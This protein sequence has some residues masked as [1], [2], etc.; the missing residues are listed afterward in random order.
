MFGFTNHSTPGQSVNDNLVCP[1][2]DDGDF[3][4]VGLKYHL[5][6]GHCD[7]FNA[8]QTETP[9]AG[10]IDACAKNV[11]DTIAVQFVDEMSF[12]KPMKSSDGK[13]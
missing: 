13:Q 4:D 3:D 1:F 9:H 7:K 11:E 2:C 5:L 8:I 12:L 6:L 10:L